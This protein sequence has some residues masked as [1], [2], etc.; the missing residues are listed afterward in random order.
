MIQYRSVVINMYR[1]IA[2]ADL[3]ELI[4]DIVFFTFL[5]VF[6]CFVLCGYV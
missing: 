5:S 6:K 3:M 2:H 1:F 4:F